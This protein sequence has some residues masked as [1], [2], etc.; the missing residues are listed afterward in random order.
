MVPLFV[1]R[2]IQHANN[3]SVQLIKLA[4]C[5][6]AIILIISVIILAN[7]L[8]Y[9]VLDLVT[10]EIFVCGATI[11]AKFAIIKQIIVHRVSAITCQFL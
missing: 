7:L 9:K 4:L 5:A 10:P 8:V 6:K 1:L 11:S 2:V 3:V